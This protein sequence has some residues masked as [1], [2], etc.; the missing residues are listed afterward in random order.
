MRIPVTSNASF[1]EVLSED[2][3][4]H[5][6]VHDGAGGQNHGGQLGTRRQPMSI[7]QLARLLRTNKNKQLLVQLTQPTDD[8]LPSGHT[9]C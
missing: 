3:E 8:L 4:E 5:Q 1:E 9:S 6:V 2:D 7:E